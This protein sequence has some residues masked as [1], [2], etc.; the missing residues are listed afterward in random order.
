MQSGLTKKRLRLWLSLFLLLLIVLT[1]LLGYQALSQMKW[2]AFRQHQVLAEELAGRIDD[3]LSTLIERE[4]QRSLSEYNFLNILGDEE[5]NFIQRSPL[6]N[7][8]V[9][10]NIPGLI[11]YFQVDHQGHFS[12][13]LLPIDPA[14]ETYG[15]PQSEY[16]ERLKLQQQIQQLLS[17]NELVK[18][19]IKEQIA[20]TDQRVSEEVDVP[21]ISLTEAE[22]PYHED[23][24]SKKS[25]DRLERRAISN[26]PELAASSPST[27]LGQAT[28][29]KLTAQFQDR[30][31]MAPQ[32]EMASIKTPAKRERRKEKTVVAASLAIADKAV[33]VTTFESEI[34]PFY[35]AQLNS[36][37]F[38]LFRKVWHNSQ[39]T[40]Q[41]ILFEQQAL[42]N[43]I[44]NKLFKTTALSK[45]SSLA[46]AFQGN[47]LAHFS[48][49]PEHYSL[50][51]AS[52][53]SGELLY[54]T[55][56]SAPLAR[57]Q[58]I[59]SIDH[60][61]AGSGA[62]FIYWVLT[63]L[64]LL[65]CGGFYLIYRLGL[66]QLH[67]AQQQQDFVSAVSHELKTPLT[68]IRMYGEILREGW[69]DEE[70]KRSYYDYIFHES[71]RLTRLINNVLRL[72]RMTHNEHHLDLKE[73]TISE[74]IDLIQ[75]KTS[76]PIERSGFQLQL[77]HDKSCDGKLMVDPD[78]FTQI[79]LNL[80]DNAVK[81]SAKAETKQIDIACRRLRDNRVLFT[82]RDYGPGVSKGQIKK[83]FQ[84]FYRSENELTRSTV[85]TGIGLALVKQLAQQMGAT[86]D[87]IEKSPGI[88]FRLIFPG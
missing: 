52:E 5:S 16:A 84:L 77:N 62:P 3:R 88:E 75:S 15:I 60:L 7:F 13:P 56:L 47:L 72:A 53:L 14:K 66:K 35:F 55:N 2:E 65:L 29:L 76:L 4:E 58:L 32:E 61:P 28:E 24:F 85:G 27:A 54:Q 78:A 21:F 46:V 1:T 12:S 71:E 33:R 73:V 67:L 11:G 81:F 59:F 51:S 86:V 10:T 48:G 70:K 30:Q 63:L 74:L 8:P 69:A 20:R 83:I 50:T 44:I 25:F 43:G 39:R 26:K 41:G 34:D 37:H 9:T 17:Q 68:S 42:L 49:T 87:A 82:V 19:T 45:M 57:M 64:L 6:S 18:T 22:T 80:V 40:T 36:G 79:I 23:N 38:V 31:L